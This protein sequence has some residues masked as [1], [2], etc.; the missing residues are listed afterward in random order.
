MSCLWRVM[1][2]WRIWASSSSPWGVSRT[3]VF[4]PMISPE[5]RFCALVWRVVF[6]SKPKEAR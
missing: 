3:W 1:G 6:V 4:S 2:T 5:R